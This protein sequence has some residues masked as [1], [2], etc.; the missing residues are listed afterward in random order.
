MVATVLLA[1][2]SMMIGVLDAT[3]AEANEARIGDQEYPTFEAAMDAAMGLSGDVTIIVLKNVNVT[4][5]TWN[6]STLDSLTICGIVKE[7]GLVSNID[8]NGIDAGSRPYCPI[9]RVDSTH[10]FTF[11]I[12]GMT[13]LNDI[14]FDSENHDVV[15]QNCVFNGSLSSYIKAKSISYLN[16]VFEFKGT[17]SHFYNGNAYAVW[18]KCDNNLDLNFIG[19]IVIGPRGIHFETRNSD[20][21]VQFEITGNKFTLSDTDPE[22]VS[23]TVALQLVNKITGSVQFSNNYI[24]AYMGVCLYHGLGTIAGSMVVENN[25]VTEGNKLIGSDEWNFGSPELADAFAGTIIENGS[26]EIS[27]EHFHTMVDGVCS[28]CGYTEPVEPV[29]PPMIYDDDDDY[30]PPAPVM[31]VE[32]SDN[33][34]SVTVI[35]CAAAV[36]VAVLMATFLIVDGRKR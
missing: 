3:E 34:D 29:R 14:G 1:S 7:V 20:K 15:V 12:D 19:N 16:N 24:D 10:N 9:V 18:Y 17:P 2:S 31:P 21:V 6:T 4:S 32:S 5:H 13:F 25:Y 11:I 26:V 36:V 27:E 28:I 30:Y 23:K 8:G 22:R 35:A 33:G